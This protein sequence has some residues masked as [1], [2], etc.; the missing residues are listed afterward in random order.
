MER[1][2][3]RQWFSLDNRRIGDHHGAKGRSGSIQR[4]HDS[5]RHL[6][7]IGSVIHVG[8][9]ERS[10]DLKIRNISKAKLIQLS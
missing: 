6:D 2:W 1:R 9:I 8:A 3:I 7:K 10:R 5:S 4:D